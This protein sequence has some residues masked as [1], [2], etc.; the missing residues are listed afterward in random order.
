MAT[1]AAAHV[2]SHAVMRAR[3]NMLHMQHGAEHQLASAYHGARQ[4]LAAHL[5]A[6]VGRYSTALDVWKQPLEEGERAI[7]PMTW[8]HDLHGGDYPHLAAAVTMEM[9]AF[10]RAAYNVTTSAKQEAVSIGSEGAQAA[11]LAAVHPIAAQ[12]PNGGRIFKQPND[13]TV[14]AFVDRAR[15]GGPLAR[16]FDGFGP[17]E[18]QALHD[19]I[20]SGLAAGIN[21]KQLGREM[22]QTIDTLGYGRAVTICRTETIHAWNHAALE[23]YRANA[24]IVTSW[25]WMAEK[26][27]ACAGC[28]AM[29]GTMHDLDE[30]LDDHVSGRCTKAPVTKGYADIL[31]DFG[32]DAS[33][34]DFGDPPWQS[35]QSGSD[36]LDEQDA[37]TQRAAFGGNAAYQAWKAGDATLDD[38]AAIRRDATWGDSIAQAS[39]KSLGLDASDYSE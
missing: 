21:P 33:D 22:S 8:L 20:A 16:L 13:Q 27:G 28:L 17:D 29:D 19:T 18:A 9:R 10:G 1:L 15:D 4:H 5:S 12:L 3:T 14:Q 34:E 23:N 31:S 26:G 38:Y 6:F 24:D 39:L 30:D 36:W 2:T 25:Q 32:I 35:Y 7:V 37:A 11:M